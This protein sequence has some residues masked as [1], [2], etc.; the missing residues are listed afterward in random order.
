[1]ATENNSDNELPA[2]TLYH[3]SSSQS[4]RILWALEELS[5]SRGLEYN[6]KRYRRE[7]GREYAG[8]KRA[9]PLGKSPIL[10]IPGVQL[11]R[12]LPFIYN[13]ND[14][15]RTIVTESR[16]ILQFLSDHYS[17]GEWAP[18]S[19]EDKDRDLYFQEFANATLSPAVDRIMY[20]QIIP[21]HAPWIVRPLMYGI[22][23]PIVKIFS[24][25][26]DG[27]FELMER[28]L[29]DEKPWFSGANLGLADFNLSWPMDSVSQRGV[30]DDKKYPKVAAWLER[31]HARP[32]Y[33]AAIKKGSPYDLV[34]FEL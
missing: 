16:L 20:F 11:F 5:L 33:Q 22:F 4:M 19:D 32:A 21:P 26:V 23:N 1:M 30:F 10:E 28:A 25:D 3:L 7:R 34:R 24:G 14:S 29:S 12:P 9:F 15:P 27:P 8:M 13:S 18:T 31:V 2:P 6:L 17:T